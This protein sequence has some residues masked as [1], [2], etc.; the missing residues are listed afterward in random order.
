M[1]DRAM[2]ME[3][4]DTWLPDFIGWA[5]IPQ[6]IKNDETHP[7]H[8]DAVA[9]FDR[10]QKTVRNS[11]DG[12][13]TSPWTDQDRKTMNACADDVIE[14]LLGV[15]ELVVSARPEGLTS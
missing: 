12:L 10:A 11:Y 6:H 8:A 1:I 13:D 14:I 7:R 15:A 4:A 2:G 5:E 3:L 9:L